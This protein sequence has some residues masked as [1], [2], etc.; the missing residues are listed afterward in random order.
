M[1]SRH[2]WKIRRTCKP[3]SSGISPEGPKHLLIGSFRILNAVNIEKPFNGVAI[4]LENTQ[5]PKEITERWQVVWYVAADGNTNRKLRQ[6]LAD[7]SGGQTFTK[8]DAPWIVNIEPAGYG[9]RGVISVFSPMP[10]IHVGNMPVLQTDLVQ[11]RLES[12]TAKF[13]RS[14]AEFEAED[15]THQTPQQFNA[16]QAQKQEINGLK[17]LVQVNQENL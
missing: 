13:N 7:N 5:A 10:V 8:L 15:A 11:S 14:A 17:Q 6:A 9:D 3:R 2:P 12:L 4:S 16:L 1:K